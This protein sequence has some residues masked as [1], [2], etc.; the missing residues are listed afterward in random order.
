MSNTKKMVANIEILSDLILSTLSNEDI[1]SFKSDPKSFI[2]ANAEQDLTHMDIFVVENNNDEVNISLPYYSDLDSSQ[3][4]LIKERDLANVSGGEIVAV[5]TIIATVGS[6]GTVAAIG[7][8]ITLVA[9]FVTAA[10][11]VIGYQNQAAE[12]KNL[13]GSK[14]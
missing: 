5:G 10:G 9:G 11:L 3:V 6:I 13:D 7:G 14:K 1:A 8:F 12:G 2:L 4:R